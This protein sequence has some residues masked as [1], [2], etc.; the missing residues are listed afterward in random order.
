MTRDVDPWA[1][2]DIEAQIHELMQR[3]NAIT[4]D[5]ADY[6]RRAAAAEHLYRLALARATLTAEGKTVAEREAAALL[7]VEEQHWTYKEATAT[8]AAT[9]EAGRMVRTQLDAMRTLAANVR[10]AM[11]NA[12]GVGG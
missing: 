3:A 4:I 12:L 11:A 6:S 2:H 5:L 8:L 9:Q 1:M 10:P 7:A